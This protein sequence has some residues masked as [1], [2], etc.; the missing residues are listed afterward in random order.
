[1]A[2]EYVTNTLYRYWDIPYNLMNQ[3]RI[4]SWQSADQFEKLFLT[5]LFCSE[6]VPVTSVRGFAQLVIVSR[7]M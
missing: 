6:I 1:M 4:V 7:A 2:G 3:S 5:Y